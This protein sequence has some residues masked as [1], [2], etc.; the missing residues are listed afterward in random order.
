MHTLSYS[1]GYACDDIKMFHE[2]HISVNVYP[3]FIIVLK[4]ERWRNKV[5][6]YVAILYMLCVSFETAKS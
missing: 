2:H 1:T 6:L 3:K 4:R 5:I